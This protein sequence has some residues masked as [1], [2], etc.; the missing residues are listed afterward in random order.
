M[1]ALTCK[2]LGGDRARRVLGC[3]YVL[4]LPSGSARAAC[5][6]CG[7]F[8]KAK[9]PKMFNIVGNIGPLILMI[10]FCAVVY[11]YGKTGG[12]MAKG[13]FKF[14]CQTP[15]CSSYLHMVI[16]TCTAQDP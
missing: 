5:V 9:R 16:T 7:R 15:L 3:F 12:L 2:C 13:A 6:S 14:S 4:V 1:I 8:A 10:I 11:L